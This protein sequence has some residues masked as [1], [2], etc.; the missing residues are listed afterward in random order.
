[1]SEKTVDEV[2]K[3]FPPNSR[4]ATRPLVTSIVS[5]Q[6][7]GTV[8][9]KDWYTRVTRRLHYFMWVYNMGYEDDLWLANCTDHRRRT[10]QF[11]EYA[12]HLCT[13]ETIQCRAIRHGTVLKY[14]RDAAGFVKLKT[15]IDPRCEL[16]STRIA[17]PIKKVTDEYLR[18][19]KIP[20]RREPW[21]VEMQKAFDK[22]NREI[23][24]ADKDDTL[25]LALADWCAL[26][27]STGYRIGEWAQPNDNKGDIRKPD[28]KNREGIIA[29]MLPQDFVFFDAKGRR[30]SSLAEAVQR[31]IAHVDRVRITW[32]VQKNGMN[33]ERKTYMRNSK[34][35]DLCPVNRALRIVARYIR[36]VGLNDPLVPLGCYRHPVNGAQL[37]VS[38]EIETHMR[39]IVAELYGLD[40][41]NEADK[42]ELSKWSAHS[43]RVGACQIL[44]ALGF[45]AY[46]IQMILRWKSDA[47]KEYLRD[48]AWVARKQAKAMS[49]IAEATIEPFL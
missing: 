36:V 2:V 9:R 40:P 43:L 12:T 32:R 42:K 17:D 21:T 20:D 33:G 3:L 48:I 45:H 22:A 15:G 25:P 19:E 26:G 30:I 28:M 38:D 18:W 46:E 37:I 11:A 34:S 10:Y 35:P 31:G 7:G 4:A 49:T 14:L 29:A 24:A 39:A 1:M 6:G 13:G 5:L 27:L 44:Y 8:T 47:F 16:D 41:D 23:D